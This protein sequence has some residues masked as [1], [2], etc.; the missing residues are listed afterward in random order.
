LLRF[1][2]KIT[3]VAVDDPFGIVAIVL[4]IVRE[5][6][7]DVLSEVLADLRLQSTVYATF[8]CGA[9][10]SVRY[11]QG[12]GAGFH[13]VTEGRCLLEVPG[14]PP[15][16]LSAGDFVVLPHGTPH[17]LRATDG[18]GASATVQALIAARPAGSTEPIPVGAGG[19]P[20]RY[21]CGA[22]HFTEPHA[23]PV[24][25]A[26][27]SVIHV[28]GENGRLLPWLDMHLQFIA[29]E[30]RSGRPGGQMVLARLSDILFVQAI[31]AH[32]AQLEEGVG[33]WL[34][35]ARDAQ[36]GQALALMH[37]SPEREWTVGSLAAAA[38]R[39]A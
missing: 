34:D 14:E 25:A 4:S 8:A 10:W 31:R 7:M 27:P 37:R 18:A 36:I 21:I 22:F 5:Y 24:L 19:E 30:A 35:A 39:A 32:L 17:L 38:P 26:L 15:I 2:R 28:P 9:P 29:C 13:V 23:S 33:G 6:G 16:E 1:G 20:T 3:F 11:D 12:P